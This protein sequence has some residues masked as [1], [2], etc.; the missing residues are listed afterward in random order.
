[1]LGAVRYGGRAF[2]ALLLPVLASRTTPR[3]RLIAG[4]LGL[5]VA[6]LGQVG[7]VGR[8]DAGLWAFGFGAANGWC[9]ALFC[10]LAMEASDP[11]MAAST[12]MAM[13]V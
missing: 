13:R 7:V 3:L 2:G 9:D 8:I 10:V 12:S 6:T 1:M 4:L 11:R 5:A